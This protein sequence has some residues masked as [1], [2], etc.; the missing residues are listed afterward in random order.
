MGIQRPAFNIEG[1]N[2]REGGRE[3]D[4]ERGREGVSERDR[5]RG[6]ERE[7]ERDRER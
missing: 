7:G 5:E 2:E 4:R 3:R 6:R 1:S